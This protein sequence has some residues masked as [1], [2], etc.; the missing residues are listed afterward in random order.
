M[1][2]MTVLGYP[3]IGEVTIR[4]GHTYP[5][6]DIPMMSDERWKQLSVENAI[7]NYTRE[8]GHAPENAEVAVQWQRDRI[9]QREEAIAISQQDEEDDVSHEL[10]LYDLMDDLGCDR[11]EA[12]LLLQDREEAIARSQQEEE[13]R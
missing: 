8:V 13:D 7:S 3:V 9:A 6:V 11:D 2:R 10:E 5:L 12:E 4:S 1:Q